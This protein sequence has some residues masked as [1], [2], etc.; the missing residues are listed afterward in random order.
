MLAL[1]LTNE[2][3]FWG[4]H[5]AGS[6]AGVTPNRIDTQNIVDIGAIRGCSISSF[7]TL[8]GKVYFWGFANG[9]YIPAPVATEFNSMT[10]LFLSLDTPAMLE[11]LE[12]DWKEPVVEKFG[13][14]FDDKVS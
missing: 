9:H 12:S 3:Y 4:I 6:A 13:L 5:Y 2:A 1:S 7:R 8:D 14:S 11:P 10:Q